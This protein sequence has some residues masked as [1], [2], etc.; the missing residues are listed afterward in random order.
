F[1]GAGAGGVAHNRNWRPAVVGQGGAWWRV[2]DN[3]F[4]TALSATSTEVETGFAIAGGTAVR[5]TS[6][7]SYADF[8]GG[9]QR[10]HGVLAVG[11]TGGVRAGIQGVDALEAWGFAT[12]TAWVAPR[13]A[14][15]ATVGRALED[16][17]RGV[18]RAQYASVAIR[19]A[20]QPH[21]SLTD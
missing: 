10:D 1:A 12:A 8:S 16:L 5:M 14:V 4:V 6:R 20:L 9:W 15:V 13:A 2:E 18:P 7:V 11:V 3:Q 21:L 17:V 19:V